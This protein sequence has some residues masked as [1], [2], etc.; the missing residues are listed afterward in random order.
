MR[1]Y[2]GNFPVIDSRGDNPIIVQ[3]DF[4]NINILNDKLCPFIFFLF[5]TIA[6][7]NSYPLCFYFLS[8]IKTFRL[9]LK[10]K[11]R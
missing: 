8:E 2:R 9:T 4:T 11:L 6:R 10:K 3:V 5:R 1:S 7:I